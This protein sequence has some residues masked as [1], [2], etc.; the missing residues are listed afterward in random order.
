[1]RS[2]RCRTTAATMRASCRS[3]TLSACSASRYAG[4]PV[5]VHRPLC[6]PP[7]TPEGRVAFTDRERAISQRVVARGPLRRSASPTCPTTPA[8]FCLWK[9]ACTMGAS[10]CARWCGPDRPATPTRRGGK[11]GWSLTWKRATCHAYVAVAAGA[12]APVRGHTG[13]LFLTSHCCSAVSHGPPRQAVRLCLTVYGRRNVRKNAGN[14]RAGDVQP[15]GWVNMLLMDF[16][17]VLAAGPVKLALW[18]KD[19][20]NPIGMQAAA[21]AHSGAAA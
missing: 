5:L 9:A 7:H 10:Y 6:P 18:P 17:G 1:M 8:R 12:R 3:G 14:E 21:A 15:V 4:K 2:C 20:A 19:I 16:R 13:Q 11:S